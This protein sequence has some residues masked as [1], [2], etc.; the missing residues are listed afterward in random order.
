[1]RDKRCGIYRGNTSS[2][3]G[4]PNQGGCRK[5]RNSHHNNPRLNHIGKYDTPHTA[6]RTVNEDDHCRYDNTCFKGNP[7]AGKNPAAGQK[8]RDKNP[9]K[10]GHITDPCPETD[11]LAV[12]I[13]FGKKVQGHVSFLLSQLSRR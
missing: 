5:N 10:A 2:R 9:Q 13:S 1:M 11:S 3:M 6:H 4:I 8:L 12:A 7:K